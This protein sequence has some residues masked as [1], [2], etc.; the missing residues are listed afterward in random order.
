MAFADS[1]FPRVTEVRQR[2]TRIRTELVNVTWDTTALDTAL[3][4]L[5]TEGGDT[6]LPNGF[7]ETEAVM[8][9]EFEA[10]PQIMEAALTLY[11]NEFKQMAP[12]EPAAPPQTVTV[13]FQ[14]ASLDFDD[15]SPGAE[16]IPVKITTSDGQPLVADVDV[17]VRD[18]LTGTAATPGEYTFTTPQA[19]NFAA[20]E[21]DGTIKNAIFTVVFDGNP[22]D[23]TVNLDLDPGTVSGA[24]IGAQGTMVV[25]LTFAIP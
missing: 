16:N 21:P 18:L 2:I 6:P 12:T 13:E 7:T 4:A 17:D 20:G 9:R 15:Q 11:E 3:K 5:R 23:T 10:R 19:L 1:S 22:P 14:F 25:N 8:Q 24:T